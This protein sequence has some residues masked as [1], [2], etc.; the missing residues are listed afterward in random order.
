MK[1]AYL[2]RHTKILNY[3]NL[4][5]EEECNTALHHDSALC[6]VKSSIPEDS[7]SYTKCSIL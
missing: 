5:K 3:K 4:H 7:L 2:L 6:M 1:T